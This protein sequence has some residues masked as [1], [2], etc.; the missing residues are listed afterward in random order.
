MRERWIDVALMLGLFCVA[1]IIVWTLFGAPTP[2]IQSAST[3]QQVTPP[4][5][6]ETITPIQPDEAVTLEVETP[7]TPDMIETPSA[8]SIEATAEETLSVQLPEGAFELN[9]IGFSFVTGGAGACGMVLEPWKH[10]AVSRDILAKYPC[11]STFSIQLDKSVAGRDS[12]RA[13]VGDTMNPVHNLTVNVYVATDE[14]A[15]EYG[16]QDGS[17]IP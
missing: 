1:G 13:V 6:P 15:L 11:G 10:V 2:Q 14:P 5:E 16:L 12:F 8:E 3:P 17:L 9:R 4:S 7:T